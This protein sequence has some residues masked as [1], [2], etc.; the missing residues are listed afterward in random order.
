MTQHHP[1][2]VKPKTRPTHQWDHSNARRIP[3]C[4]APGGCDQ[5][6][7]DCKHCTLVRVTVHPPN[8][9]AWREWRNTR[10]GIQF[11]ADGTPPCQPK[12]P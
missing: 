1:A 4:D 11:T 7:R 12:A 9:L 2:A 3:A 8:G 10:Q 6:E 5:T